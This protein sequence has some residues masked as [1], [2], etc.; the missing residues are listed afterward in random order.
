MRCLRNSTSE[1]SG[2]TLGSVSGKHPPNREQENAHREDEPE[3][4]GKA[5]FH[6][7]LQLER[8]MMHQAAKITASLERSCISGKCKLKRAACLLGSCS[9]LRGQQILG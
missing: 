3:Q 8:W 7:R 2:S 1:T 4:D 9:S 6:L 5:D